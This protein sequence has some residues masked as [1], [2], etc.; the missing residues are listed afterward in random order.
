[1]PAGTFHTQKVLGSTTWTMRFLGEMTSASTMWYTQSV[2]FGM[3]KSE[4][5][6]TDKKG[7]VN[8]TTIRMLDYGTSAAHSLI[9]ST[10]RV[11]KP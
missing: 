2:P 9:T 5:R 7:G 11:M 6:G 8:T 3:V 1:V 4:D 10:P